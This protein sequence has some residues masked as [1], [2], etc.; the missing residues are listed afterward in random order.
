MLL[1]A[2]VSSFQS[3]EEA[4]LARMASLM[5]R[6]QAEEAFL[7]VLAYCWKKIIHGSLLCNVLLDLIGHSPRQS[8]SLT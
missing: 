8:L 3:E 6:N 2:F 5:R 7:R 1:L 4:S